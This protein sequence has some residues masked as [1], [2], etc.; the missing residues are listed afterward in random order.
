MDFVHLFNLMEQLMDNTFKVTLIKF[1]LVQV[2]VNK[3]YRMRILK[4]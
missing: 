3:A 2:L 1:Q 4:I